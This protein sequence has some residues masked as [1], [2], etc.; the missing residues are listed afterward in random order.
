MVWPP[1][2][3]DAHMIMNI[4]SIVMFGIIVLGVLYSVSNIISDLCDQPK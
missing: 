2:Y 1:L 3:H 4:N